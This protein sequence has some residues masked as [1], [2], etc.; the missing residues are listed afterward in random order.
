MS[1][2][3]QLPTAPSAQAATERCRLLRVCRS[4]AYL[5]LC[6][7]RVDAHAV[8]SLQV[9]PVARCVELSPPCRL[10]T[11]GMELCCGTREVAL[12][13][14]APP[15]RVALPLCSVAQSPGDRRPPQHIGPALPPRPLEVRC[16]PASRVRWL[17]AGRRLLSGMFASAPRPGTSGCHAWA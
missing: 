15:V 6:G 1:W 5:A 8:P 16:L 7:T 3:H 4:G 2:Q 14:V 11:A 17:V 10:G 12:T 13:D 9:G